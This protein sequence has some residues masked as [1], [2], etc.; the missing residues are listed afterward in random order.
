LRPGHHAELDPRPGLEL[1]HAVRQHIA[2]DEDLLALVVGE[3]AEAF[4][5]LNHFTLPVGT[6]SPHLVS[7]G[8]KTKGTA[9]AVPPGV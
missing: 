4:S 2:V 6:E 5:A 1:G 7:H 3:E 9:R 8:V